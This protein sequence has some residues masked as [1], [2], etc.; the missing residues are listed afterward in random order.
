[1]NDSKFIF[2]SFNNIKEQ[3]PE[4]ESLGETQPQATGNTYSLQETLGPPGTLP[5]GNPPDK[6]PEGLN[7]GDHTKGTF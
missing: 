5:Y 2:L 7:Q 1:M 4:L 6:V 3:P